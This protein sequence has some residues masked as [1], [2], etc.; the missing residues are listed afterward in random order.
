MK[1]W[2]PWAIAGT[3]SLLGGGLAFVNPEATSLTIE[4]VLGWTFAASAVMGLFAF[5]GGTENRSF[6][7]LALSLLSGIC[8]YIL[9]T[10]PMEGVLALSLLV[11]ALLLGSGMSQLMMAY[12]NR[13]SGSFWIVLAS[14]VISILLGVMLLTGFPKTG[15]IMLGL[16]F[17]I[18]LVTNGLSL[19]AFSLTLRGVE[20][21]PLKRRN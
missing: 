17:A 5:I 4:L 9:I 3:I 19:L 11:T 7:G 12:Q 16:I 8:A 21:A 14:G 6:W 18:E 1:L 15:E 10:H 13:I 2:A 20:T